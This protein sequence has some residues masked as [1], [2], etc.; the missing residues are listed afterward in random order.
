VQPT[1]IEMRLFEQVESDRRGG[2]FGK[3]AGAVALNR[4][5]PQ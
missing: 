2:T 5:L 1:G 3:A 4:S